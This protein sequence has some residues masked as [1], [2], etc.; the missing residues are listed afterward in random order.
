VSKIESVH[1]CKII[2]KVAE[3]IIFKILENVFIDTTSK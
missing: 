3:H 2:I 1:I